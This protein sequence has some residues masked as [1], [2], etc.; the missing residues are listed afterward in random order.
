MVEHGKCRFTGEAFAALTLISRRDGTRVRLG[1]VA[2]LRDAFEDQPVLSRL[3]GR[4]SVTLEV[5]RVG[6]QNVLAMTDRLRRF[7]EDKRGELPPGVEL[8]TWADRSEY[9]TGRINLMLKSALQGAVLVML[10]LALFLNL[11][12]AFWVILGVPFSFLGA[13]LMIEVLELSV[14]INIISVFGF[15]LVLGMLVDD[16]IIDGSLNA[17]A[18]GTRMVG[19]VGSLFQTGRVA[20]YMFW[21][22]TGV[23]LILALLLL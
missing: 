18:S 6:D 3:N 1:D 17:L 12:L 20:G 14:T 13:L 11:S 22:V 8:V 2:T 21:F 10:T 15:I 7:V 16:G 23:V 19:W 9:L 5:D 4:P